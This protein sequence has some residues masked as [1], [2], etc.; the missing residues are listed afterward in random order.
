MKRHGLSKVCLMAVCVVSGA[1]GFAGCNPPQ[2]YVTFERL[3]RGLVIVLPGIEGRGVFN[4]AICD[5]LDAGGVDCAIE[6]YDWT[7]RWAG[8]LYNLR[9]TAANRRRARDLADRIVRY[10]MGYPDRPV[11]LVGQS[12]GGA[13]AVWT[14]EA[15]PPATRVDG[16]VLLAA[17][18]SPNY[19]LSAALEN[20]RRGIVNYH[21]KRDVILLA[22]YVAG[23][24]DGELYDSAG[25]TGFHL[26]GDP[27]R[28]PRAYA[29]LF[30]IGWNEHMSR[31][32]HWGGHL[33]SGAKWYVA[34]YVAPLVRAKEWD[35]SLADRVAAS[36]MFEPIPASPTSASPPDAHGADGT[37]AKPLS[38][39]DGESSPPAAP[40][41]DPVTPPAPRPAVPARPAAEEAIPSLGATA[42]PA[43]SSGGR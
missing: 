35:Q 41:R 25:R 39:A 22:T 16:A 7:Q 18:L 5:G 30:Q 10:Q 8:P 2:P 43:G 21:S 17:A 32:G 24:M 33:T 34:Q 11:V 29:K 27:N 40:L 19:T 15:L 13:M 26:P 12:G 31:S 20:C 3:E 4:E 9:N 38:S 28:L 23:T 36:T 37:P 14:L 42:A 6:L 1:A